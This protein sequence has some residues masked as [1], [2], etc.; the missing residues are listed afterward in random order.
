MLALQAG[1]PSS[2]SRIHIQMPDVVMYVQYRCLGSRN[3]DPELAGR[4]SILTGEL[5]A[6]ER[7]CLVGSI[8][9]GDT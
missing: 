7:I 9:E 8:P 5:Q 2:I 1:Y 3:K 6:N 4:Q